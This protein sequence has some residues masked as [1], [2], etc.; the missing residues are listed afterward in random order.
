MLG[1]VNT[2]TIPI[3]GKGAVHRFKN[4]KIKLNNV[5][6][7]SE[8]RQNLLSVTFFDYKGASFK[9]GKVKLRLLTVIMNVYFLL[10]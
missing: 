8:L 10:N 4:T 6:Y 9:E 7:A 3:K 1:D 2:F 5:A